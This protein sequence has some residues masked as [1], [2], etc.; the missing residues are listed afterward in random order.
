[1]GFFFS[2]EV[3]EEL[4]RLYKNKKYNDLL[5]IFSQLE[6]KK[7]QDARIE[8]LKSLV[9]L[10][11]GN[12][13]KAIEILKKN[14]S[15]DPNYL[16]TY[17]NLGKI[18]LAQNNLEQSK[19]IFLE[20]YK[21]NNQ[22]PYVL[23]NLGILSI[24]ERN[25]ESAK[26]YFHDCL[27]F[28]PE[29][30][31]AILNLANIDYE[32]KNY[33]SAINAYK[34]ILEKK[35]NF[36]TLKN[37]GYCYFELLDIENSIYFLKK[38]L[39]FK[40]D[41]NLLFQISYNYKI[42]G[43]IDKSNSYLKKSY[44]FNPSH[45]K[46]IF[47]ISKSNISNL[48]EIQDI[49]KIFDAEKNNLSKA[50]LGF[51]LFNL[52]N[53]NN[54]FKEASY[55]LDAANQMIE[56]TINVKNL[57]DKK[58]FEI[59]KKNFNQNHFAKSR[60]AS[61]SEKCPVIFIVGMPRSGSTLIEQ[62]IS[63]HSKIYSFGEKNYLY[64]SIQYFYPNLKLDDFENDIKKSDLSKFNNLMKHYLALFN[65]KH[66]KNSYFTDKMLNNFRFI[67][68]IKSVFPDAKIIYCK[69][70]L[71][72]NWLSI[73]SNYF[74]KNFLPWVYNKQLLVDYIILQNNLMKHWFDLFENEIFIAEYE[75]FI[76]DIE[77]QSKKIINYLELSWEPQ[78][79]EFYENTNVVQTASSLQVREKLYKSSIGQWKNYKDIYANF[80]NQLD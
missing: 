31:S 41:Q 21:I 27:I 47:S 36:E 80:F 24:Q 15:E 51:S 2:T 67:G 26:K 54:K 57:N 19:S 55:Y 29:N 13:Q 71:K 38:A 60:L 56:K 3:L 4:Y 70:N 8:N 10:D 35:P 20:A 69:R 30:L 16:D 65:I 44:S 61:T 34:K 18:Y 49:K 66:E 50:E 79:L 32:Q 75:E 73:Y 40:L 46:T 64:E 12:K 9:Y 14:I 74:G 68:F 39:E 63:S 11:I 7:I 78:C 62:I 28:N 76:K 52:L 1:M 59:Y 25:F 42:L 5:N 72:D 23:N 77:T 17:I 37:L 58:E 43:N 33:L 45:S 53:K 48:L 6:K 22:D